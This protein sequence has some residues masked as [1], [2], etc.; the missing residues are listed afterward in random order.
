M[1]AENLHHHIT[2]PSICAPKQL[3]FFNKVF[4]F[5]YI[6]LSILQVSAG[7]SG[8]P[9]SFGCTSVGSA[10]YSCGCPQ[11]YQRIG[12]GHC[13]STV[14]PASVGYGD[15]I[16]NVPTYPINNNL[17]SV[18]D[19]KLIT[20]EGC[21]SCRVRKIIQFVKK[22]IKFSPERNNDVLFFLI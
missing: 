21:F 16:G 9:C 12:Q 6:I 3:T 2:F 22:C 14:T 18:S 5:L 10:G 7:C 17:K 4:Y 20:T 19:D 8:A 13:L 11:G 15:D 1:N